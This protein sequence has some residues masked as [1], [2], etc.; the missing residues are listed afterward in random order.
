VTDGLVVSSDRHLWGRQGGEPDELEAQVQLAADG[1][2]R[3]DAGR[4][5][6]RCRCALQAAL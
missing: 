2:H 6:A 1:V 4:A 3:R 5:G